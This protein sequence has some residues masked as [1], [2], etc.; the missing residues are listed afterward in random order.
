MVAAGSMNNEIRIYT[1]DSQRAVGSVIGLPDAVYS[2]TMSP[3]DRY[4]AA[5]GGSQALLVFN[6]EERAAD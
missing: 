6:V 3:S 2:V 5:G 1:T 4:V